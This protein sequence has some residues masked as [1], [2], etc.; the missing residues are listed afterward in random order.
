[1]VALNSPRSGK[2]G[3]SADCKGP[4]DVSVLSVLV[5]VKVVSGPGFSLMTF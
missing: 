4:N 1:M 5:L 3:Y 2:A